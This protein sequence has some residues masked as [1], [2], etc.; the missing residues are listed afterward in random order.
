MRGTTV[1]EDPTQPAHPTRYHPPVQERSRAGLEEAVL[2]WRYLV[3]SGLALA[4]ASAQLGWHP[5]DWDT[6]LVG[7][8]ILV[9]ADEPFTF[10]PGGL[11]VLANYPEQQTGPLSLLFVTPFTAL[12]REA[13]W[14]MGALLMSMASPLLVWRLEQ[15][16]RAGDAPVD[17]RRLRIAVLAGGVVLVSA[18]TPLA[19]TYGKVDDVLTLASIVVAMSFVADRR[20]VAAGVAI[21]LAMA[22]KPWAAFAA[23]LLLAVPRGRRRE[24]TAVAVVIVAACWLP[25]VLADPA[26]LTAAVPAVRVGTRSILH[27]LG[28]AAVDPPSWIRPAQLLLM[29]ALALGAVCRGRWPAVLLVGVAGR[30][31]VDPQTFTY[32]TSGLVLGALAWDL[33]GER[34]SVPWWT[35]GTFVSLNLAPEVLP[36]RAAAAARLVT[37][38]AIVVWIV[39]RPPSDSR[40]PERYERR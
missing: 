40:A 32:Y 22:F 7:A 12:G 3:L 14:V 36:D 39:L 23:V 26:T 1:V 35:L 24:P 9:G 31:I 25:F 30:L 21:G 13:A 29:A 34:R 17:E 2:R 28:V 8:R 18:W 15:A 4:Y 38:V 37:L 33:C 10:L 11:R 19:L 5:R 6:A 20:F 16:A 27:L